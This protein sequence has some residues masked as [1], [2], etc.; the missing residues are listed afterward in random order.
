MLIYLTV[1]VKYALE[2]ESYI[3]YVKYPV[4]SMLSIDS[5]KPN[6]TLFLTLVCIYWKPLLLFT[7]AESSK[8]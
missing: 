7:A 3:H 2:L 8:F 6:M 5:G 1:T 4:N